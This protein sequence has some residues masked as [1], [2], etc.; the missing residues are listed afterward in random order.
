MD[1]VLGVAIGIAT[2]CLIFSIFASH[3]QEVWASFSAR[4]ASSLEIALRNMLGDEQLTNA[5]FSHPLIQSISFAATRTSL[6]G[7]SAPV[8][9]RPSYIPSDQF[10]KVLQSILLTA[11]N[12]KPTD[13]SGLIAALPDSSLKNRLKALTLGLEHDVSACN[14]AVE[15]WYDDTMDR[16]NGLYKRHTQVSLLFLGLGLAVLCNVNLLRV[17]RA[18]WTSAPT[19][20][21]LVSLAEEYKCPDSANCVD[22]N[23][24]KARQDLETNLA[25]LPIGYQGFQLTSYLAEVRNQFPWPILGTWVV[26]L[27][28]WILTAFAVSLGAPFWFDLVNKLVNVRMVGQKPATADSRNTS[29]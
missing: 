25:S 2:V 21:Q 1:K 20:A 23:Y 11:N 10:N 27:L 6:T 16:I 12:L 13:L 3:L 18:L 5:L 22:L 17:G 15:K 19:R 14:T 8:V 9:P 7:T 24:W 4:R 28:G 26:N 29:S